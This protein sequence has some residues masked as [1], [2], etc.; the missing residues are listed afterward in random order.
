MKVIWTLKNNPSPH[1]Q[2]RATEFPQSS[3]LIDR[4]FMKAR[5]NPQSPPPA[6]R[7]LSHPRSGGPKTRENYH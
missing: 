1:I 4:R 7:I 3:A 2:A 5:R 6:S